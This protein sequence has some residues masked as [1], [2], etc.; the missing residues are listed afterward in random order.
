MEMLWKLNEIIPLKGLK[1][2]KHLG[3]VLEGIRDHLSHGKEVESDCSIIL[4]LG[5][6]FKF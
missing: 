6:Q 4:V 1:H 3:A 5:E 2:R